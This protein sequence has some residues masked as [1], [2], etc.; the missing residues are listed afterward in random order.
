MLKAVRTADLGA[1][2]TE[3]RLLNDH[4]IELI[5]FICRTEDELIGACRDADAILLGP[6]EMMTRKVLAELNRCRIISHYGIGY[7]NVDCQAATERGII[8]TNVPDYCLQE[9][10]DHA[11][12]LILACSRRLLP[13]YK[14]VAGGNWKEG[15]FRITAARS[16][17]MPLYAQTIGLAGMGRIGQEVV[18]KVRGFDSEIIAW[19]PFVQDLTFQHL[20]VKRVD[21]DQLLSRSDY[22]TIHVPLSPQ[23]HHLFGLREFKKMKKSAFLVNTSRGA[24]VNEKELQQALAE[25]ELAGAA[26]DVFEEEP[27]GRDHPLLQMENVFITPHSGFFSIR[28]INEMR[29]RVAMA[30]IQVFS[31]VFPKHIVNP[32]VKEVIGDQLRDLP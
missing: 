30:I 28:S 9:V 24:V 23:T 31:G 32:K 6:Y 25:G 2:E 1:E 10:S 8:V 5:N 29:E 22:L 3:Q 26:L 13:L 7:D 18:R 17:I 4:G 14:A 15:G 12:A 16:D 21:F 11:M 19:D 27:I 20:G